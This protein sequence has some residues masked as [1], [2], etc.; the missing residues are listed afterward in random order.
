[1]SFKRNR[2]AGVIYQ[3]FNDLK[4]KHGETI[5]MIAT[6]E[7]NLALEYFK[8]ITLPTEFKS[9]MVWEKFLSL[10]SDATL[11][12][13][14]VEWDYT[15]NDLHNAINRAQTYHD[16][17]GYA[18]WAYKKVEAELKATTNN[19]TNSYFD[20]ARKGAGSHNNG[21]GGGHS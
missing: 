7:E 20:N 18:P 14:F 21:K 15:H 8:K 10:C 16:N 5:A 12:E 1:M 4:R 11:K 17:H 9:V 6:R 2:P 3:E 13:K 19:N